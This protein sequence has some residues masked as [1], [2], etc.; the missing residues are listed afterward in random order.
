MKNINKTTPMKKILIKTYGFIGDILFASS[1]A[2][3]LHEQYEEVVVDY[4]IGF[5]QPYGLLKNNPY[6]NNV[7]LSKQKGPRIIPPDFL[8]DSNYS[9]VYELPE[10]LHN[11]TPTKLH[12][13]YCGIAN[14]T[15]EFKV[16]TDPILDT[17]VNWEIDTL[18]LNNAKIIGYVA[19]WKQS[20]IQYTEKEYNAGL[21]NINSILSHTHTHTRDIEYILNSLNDESILIPLGYDHTIT[22]FHGSLDATASYTNQASIIK[23]CDIVI[24]QEGGMTNLAAGVGT[25]CIITTD[26]MHA[27]YGYN[28]IMR[29]MEEIKLG[30]KNL[31]PNSNHIHLSPYISDGEIIN[32]IKENI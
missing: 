16:Y 28:G 23:K 2:Q 22:Q 31:F 4:C 25:K 24:G 26:F 5:P 13:R 30:P 20:T 10:S 17:S 1:I 27:L 9:D 19:N 6:I 12:Q 29:K 32:V 14:P 11:I 18:N 21:S 8:K 15:P 7:Y 3:K